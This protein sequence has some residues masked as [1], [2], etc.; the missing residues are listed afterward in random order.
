[1]PGWEDVSERILWGNGGADLGVA[2]SGY[3]DR[4][5][6]V[7]AI[8]LGNAEPAGQEPNDWTNFVQMRLI[9]GKLMSEFN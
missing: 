7:G 3:F 4:A 2:S 6:K 8:A 9:V 1:M 5:S